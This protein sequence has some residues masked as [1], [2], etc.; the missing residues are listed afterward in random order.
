MDFTLT[1]AQ[2]DLA[3][4]TRNIVTEVVTNEHLR[5][6][7]AAEDRI[8]HALWDAL[9]SSGILGAAV[10]ESIGD[11]RVSRGAVRLYRR[12]P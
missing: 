2:Q 5:E 9:A 6:L 11:I 10:P 8:D 4:L 3:G 7:D 12:T 1:E